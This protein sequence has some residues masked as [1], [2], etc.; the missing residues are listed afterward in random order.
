[1]QQP[2]AEPSPAQQEAL[3]EAIAHAKAARLYYVSDRD[4]G[5]TRVRLS[6]KEF[7]YVAPDGSEIVEAEVILRIRKLAIPPAYEGVWICVHERGHLQATGLDARRRK[8]YRYHA[9]WRSVRDN[10]KFDRMVEFGEALPRLRRRL[11]RDLARP[12]LPQE[13][14]LAVAVALLDSTL[15]RVGNIEYARDNNSFGL[16]TLRDR[17]VKFIRDGRAVFRF[18]GKSGKEHEIPVND[19]KLAR[20][21][22]HC[23]NLPGQ[24]LFKYI[25]DDGEHHP[26][27]SDQV[28]AYLEEIMGEGFSAKDFR[29]WGATERAIVL[30]SQT[31]F[32]ERESETAFNACI[33]A[34][35]KEVAQELHNTP[36]VCRKSYINPVVFEAWRDGTLHKVVRENL[37]NAPRKAEVA[38]LR[39]LRLMARRAARA[40]KRGGTGVQLRLAVAAAPPSA[41]EQIPSPP[42]EHDPL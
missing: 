42:P 5:I 35:V 36:A 26:I 31:P 12:G 20:I 7:K 24:H 19:R 9:E 41:E 39:F 25:G 2:G 10:H 16:T 1:M 11:R 22:Q 17:H 29:T 14:V 15:I 40:A 30:M 34:C 18:R 38:A 21:V 23:Q 37:S 27:D 4:P 28:N 32:P 3:A 8:Q 13:K 6:E 33:V